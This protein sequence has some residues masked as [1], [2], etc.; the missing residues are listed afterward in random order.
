MLESLL[1]VETMKINLRE[2]ILIKDRRIMCNWCK[3]LYEQNGRNLYD[4]CKI[5]GGKCLVR[6][7]LEGNKNGDK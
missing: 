2:L 4:Q 3:V 7:K 6:K 5:Q 1:M